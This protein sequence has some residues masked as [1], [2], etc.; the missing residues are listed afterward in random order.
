MVASFVIG[1]V[2]GFGVVPSNQF[3]TAQKKYVT[4][5]TTTT[6]SL[7]KTFKKSLLKFRSPKNDLV[8]VG[9]AHEMTSTSTTE[10][11]TS[12][13][14]TGENTSLLLLE[15]YNNIILFDGVCNFCNTWVDILLRIDTNKIFK[16]TPLQ[17]NVG[18]QLLNAIGKDQDDISSIRLIQRKKEGGSFS[19]SSRNPKNIDFIA[20]DKSACVL[21]VV[22]ELGISG[23]VFAQI[24]QT[25]VPE[26]IRDIIY[27]TV[28][29]NRYKFLGERDVCRSGDPIYFDRFIS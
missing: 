2:D 7:P 10:S 17:S 27:D 21:Q 15:K 26:S 24:I 3:S 9:T 14:V 25:I 23:I 19:S 4:T 12:T 29:E 6:N 5:T 8:N 18:K 1:V 11:T 28:A 16:F 20:Y 22:K 13:E